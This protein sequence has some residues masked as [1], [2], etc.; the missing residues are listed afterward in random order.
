MSRL[1]LV[2]L[3]IIVAPS[4]LLAAG[5]V[6]ATH[7]MVVSGDSLASEA[8]CSILR[9]GGNAVD[10][11][12]A[13]GFALAV[14]FP[15]AGNIGGGGYMLLRLHNGTSMVIDFR[16]TAPAAATR[17]MYLDSAGHPNEYKSVDGHLSAGVP[18]TV[19]GLLA[20]LEKYGSLQSQAVLAPAI[21]LAE[22][23]FRVNRRLARI[24][25]NA[26]PEF[27]NFPSTMKVFTHDG[28]PFAE[29]DTL[30]QPDL[31]RT[32]RSI[33]E[34]GEKG[35]YEGAVAELISAEMRRG[36]GMITASDLEKYRAVEREPLRGSYRDVEILTASPSSGGG[37][38]LLQMLNM[39]ERF[40]LREM[41]SSSAESINL[42]ASVAQ[43]AYADRASFLGDPAFTTIPV[44]A[45]ISKD[46]AA[47][48]ASSI[49]ASRR[50]PSSEI[51]S[52][53]PEG[54]EGH[55]T[56]HYCVVDGEGNVVSVTYTLN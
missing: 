40:P 54:K 42:I 45:L 55:Q 27:R 50:T 44:E 7:G 29:G 20:A 19:A 51:R 25:K 35:F 14:S 33:V 4:L 34:D 15:E 6:T 39:L 30:R 53:A 26:L 23:G 18:G 21:E 5:P 2:V 22:R 49:E 24:M 32:L 47:L 46:Y 41:G 10:A 37:V 43:R 8:G 12:V 36:G 38:L 1:A 16:E 17:D 52:G 13:V 9:N 3:S 31:A 28:E 56:T 11:A 48:R